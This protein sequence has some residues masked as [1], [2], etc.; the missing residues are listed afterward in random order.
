MPESSTTGGGG[1]VTRY[2]FPE[3]QPQFFS[4]LVLRQY[5]RPRPG[6][7]PVKNVGGYIRLPLP[8]NL[9]DTYNMD[10]NGVSLG[11]LGNIGNNIMES[12]D[13]L[14]AAG[15]SAGEAYKNAFTSGDASSISQI[16]AKTVALAPGVSDIL[17]K[18][19]GVNGSQVQ[20]FA[21]NQAGVV[22]NPHLTSIFEGVRLKTYEF[23]WRLSPRSQGEAKKM[24]NMINYIKAYMHPAILQN[25]GGF[26]LEYPYIATLDFQGLPPE[27][28]PV[29][30]DSFITGMSINS[31]T[32]N[33]VVLFRDGQPI[34]VDIQLHFQEININTRE[35]FGYGTSQSFDIPP[36]ST[37]YLR[38]NS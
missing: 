13:R 16:A 38:D 7:A 32:G 3:Q 20:A 25:S 15:K 1:S 35:N 8:T 27:V 12:K 23:T 10:V 4:R 18:I 28:T 9:S 2:E 24:N 37:H 36:P 11:L 17:G 26:A 6:S 30:G 34:T 19:P 21:Q 31:T 22:R 14:M 5:S 33:G 29:V